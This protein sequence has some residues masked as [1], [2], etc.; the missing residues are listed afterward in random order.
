MNKIMQQPDSLFQGGH[1]TYNLCV[2]FLKTTKLLSKF[3]QVFYAC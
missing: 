2:A 3:Q 1:C